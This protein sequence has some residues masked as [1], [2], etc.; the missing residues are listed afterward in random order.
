MAALS[1]KLDSFEGPLDLLLHLITKHKLNIKDIQIGL[2]LEQYLRY[3]DGIEEADLEYAGEFLEMAARLILIKT[4]SLL[5]VHEE[6]AVMKRELEGRLVEYSICKELS[7]RLRS[8]YIGDSVF[9]REPMKLKRPKTFSGSVSPDRLYEAYMLLREKKSRQTPV[10]AEVFKPIVSK[11]VVPVFTGILKVLRAVYR[12]GSCG[13]SEL[14]DGL[15]GRSEKIAVFL[16]VLELTR[17]GR[18]ALSEDNSQIMYVGERRHNAA[19]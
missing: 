6:A 7:K 16:A 12:G 13:V 15:E 11:R 4:L 1:Y 3:I 8:S 17:S 14:L 5:P 18:V 2:L 19:K 10:R 9:V